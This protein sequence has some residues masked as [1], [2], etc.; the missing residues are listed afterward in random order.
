MAFRRLPAL[1]SLHQYTTAPTCLLPTYRQT[2]HHRPRP[3]LSRLLARPASQW[4]RPRPTYSRFGRA[5]RLYALWLM[6]PLFRV[7]LG[8]VGVAGGVF[9][10]SNLE[11][12]PVSGRRRFNFISPEQEAA[13][14]QDGFRQVMQQFGNQVLPPNHP[15]SRLVNKVVARLLP[16]SGIQDQQWEVRVIDDPNQKNAFVM[17]GGKVFVFSGILPICAGDDGLAQVLGHEIGHSVAHHTAEKLSKS[18]FVLGL[19]LIIALTF[20]VS[21]SLAQSLVDIALNRTNSRT[22]ESE[23]DYIGLLMA[24]KA[25]YDPQ[26]AVGLWQRMAKA[27]QYA[28]PQF[29]S[30]HPASK[31]RVTQ[32]EHWLP[33]AEEV[34]SKSECGSTMGFGKTTL[35]T[36]SRIVLPKPMNG[37]DD[38]FLQLP[39][40]R[41]HL[42]GLIIGWQ[43]RLSLTTTFSEFDF[44]SILC[45]TS[46]GVEALRYSPQLL[47]A[48]HPLI[49]RLPHTL[50][51]FCR[52]L[53]QI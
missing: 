25:C 3:L 6:S 9:Y 24:A 32:L 15:Y 22:Q 29:L 8:A 51:V 47:Q 41:M 44:H 48:R 10:F 19:A 49:H 43:S 4:G 35:L 34:Q 23:A 37:A 28:P 27:E 11:Y 50:D 46:A 21:G 13:L 17:P 42:E 26:A 39:I 38:R 36:K 30:T 14:A 53:L 33:E 7:G 40:S 5:Q 12:V 18:G 52:V 1:T 16:V 45:I 2:A 20:D 31:N